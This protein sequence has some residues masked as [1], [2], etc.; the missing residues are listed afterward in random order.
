MHTAYYGIGR[1]K[2]TLSIA[3]LLYIRNSTIL[4]ISLAVDI[5][6]ALESGVWSIDQMYSL[7]LLLLGNCISCHNQI[8]MPYI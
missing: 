4:Y 5:Y 8:Y 7:L 3:W 1:G 6:E 2:K